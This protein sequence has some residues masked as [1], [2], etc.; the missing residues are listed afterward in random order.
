MVCAAASTRRSPKN[1]KDR[2]LL[3]VGQRVTTSFGHL[4]QAIEEDFM[5][6][7]SAAQITARVH[8]ILLKIDEGRE[9][10]AALPKTPSP[11]SYWTWWRGS[12]RS[13][14]GRDN[15]CDR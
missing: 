11:P 1:P 5:V 9:Q 10:A 13:R 15:L 6:P 7:G 3:A 14:Q 8:Q 12:R 4:G 2:L